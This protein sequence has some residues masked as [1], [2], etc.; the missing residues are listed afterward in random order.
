MMPLHF[1]SCLSHWDPSPQL[2]CRLPMRYVTSLIP[3][4]VKHPC[5]ATEPR[6]TAEARTTVR[7]ILTQ[8]WSSACRHLRIESY[9]KLPGK[10]GKNPHI[11][12]I[13]SA[14]FFF[15]SLGHLTLE[16]KR[17]TYYIKL[18]HLAK[19]MFHYLSKY[20]SLGEKKLLKRLGVEML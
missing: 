20:H 1:S 4:K 8:S 13:P 11:K 12:L 7:S 19:T 6:S 18:S 15:V 5:P 17:Y 3:T 10:R 14:H 16:K 9:L 2:T